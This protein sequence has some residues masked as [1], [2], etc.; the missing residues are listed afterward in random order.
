MR[1]P[2]AV[3]RDWAARA[4]EGVERVLFVAEDDEGWTGVV[5]GFRR[6]DP[7]EVQLVSMWV[8]PRARG[9]GVAQALIRAVA[10][11]ARE[12]GAARVVLFVQEVNAPGRA[13]YAKA[14]FRPTGDRMPVGTGRRGFKL[15]YAASVDELLPNASTL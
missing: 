2:D 8:D 14:G 7:M 10:T 1:E 5:G 12:L 13:L 15:V 9:T 4:A 6:V 11:W 3:W